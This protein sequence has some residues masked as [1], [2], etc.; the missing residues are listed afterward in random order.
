[1]ADRTFGWNPE[2][3]ALLRKTRGLGFEE[4]VEAILNDRL[5]A[6]I[7]NPNPNYPG[8]N[9]LVVEIE[10]YA[11]VAPYVADGNHI[12]L[13]TLYPDRKARKRFLGT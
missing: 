9:L 13:K 3:N 2:K 11:V 8:Q 12:F 10:G 7:P 1:M 5:L 4:V 6:D